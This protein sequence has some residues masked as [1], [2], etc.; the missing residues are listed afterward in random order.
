MR[1]CATWT[2]MCTSKLSTWVPLGRQVVPPRHCVY[3]GRRSVVDL[4]TWRAFRL[5]GMA[6]KLDA[7]T[8]INSNWRS[9][10]CVRGNIAVRLLYRLILL[11]MIAGSVE[12]WGM[13][14][15]GQLWSVVEV[16]CGRGLAMFPIFRE[17]EL[18]SQ[19][20]KC[21]KSLKCFYLKR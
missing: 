4:T 7:R 9:H 11:F 20:L 5:C 2:K 21:T 12:G 3:H 19:V 10:V 8:A 15:A 14:G 1:G 6:R 17:N 13:G 16:E 18:Q